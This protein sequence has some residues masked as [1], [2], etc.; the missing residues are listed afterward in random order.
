ME[1]ECQEARELKPAEQAWP[2]GHSRGKAHK[3]RK[4]KEARPKKATLVE[5]PQE[6]KAQEGKAQEGHL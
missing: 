5:S 6:K 2:G 3:R 4:P 1:V